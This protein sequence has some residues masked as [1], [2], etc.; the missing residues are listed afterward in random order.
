VLEKTAITFDG[1][2]LSSNNAARSESATEV[3]RSMIDRGRRSVLDGESTLLLG[4]DISACPYVA[5]FGDPVAAPSK[6]VAACGGRLLFLPAEVRLR[7][8]EDEA[9]SSSNL[10]GGSSA[11]SWS[12]KAESTRV[13]SFVSTRRMMWTRGH[14]LAC[15]RSSFYTAGQLTL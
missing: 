6:I 3:L 12:S 2:T 1:E 9:H 4:L 13:S 8:N 5:D 14:V 11:D 7:K 15:A 10:M